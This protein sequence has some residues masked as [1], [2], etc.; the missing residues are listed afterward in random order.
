MFK[1]SAILRTGAL[2]IGAPIVF[3][4]AALGLLLRAQTETADAERWE[5]HSKDVISRTAQLRM[6]LTRAHAAVRGAYVYRTM[7]F[8]K[9]RREALSRWP[10]MLAD[11]RRF[12]ADNPGQQAQIDRIGRAADP[13]FA[14]FT[15]MTRLGASGQW[16]AYRGEL[17]T[18]RGKT[19]ADNVET[20]LS[21]FVQEEGHLDGQRLAAVAASRLYERNVLLLIAGL[22]IVLA[23]A[24]LVVF[25]RGFSQRLARIAVNGRRLATGDALLDPL[26]GDDE[27]AALDGVLHDSARRLA[28]AA[29]AEK[30]Y[31]AEL[32]QRGR[33]L[34]QANK[35]L[36]FRRQENETFVYSVSHDLRSP[37]VNVQ[38]FTKELTQA[39]EDLRGAIADT[40]VDASG[41]D[42][43]ARIVDHDI[44]EAVSFI[45]TAVTR[46]SS[47]VDALLRL[48]R[49]GRV[50]FSAQRVELGPIVERIT[51]AMRAT[52]E[53][54]GAHVTSGP[55]PAVLGDAVSI[56]QVFAN[57][58][59][60]AL[61]YLDPARPGRVEIGLDQRSGEAS[62]EAIV[63][64]RDNGLGIP[65]RYLSKLFVPFERLHGDV[66]KGEGIGLALAKRIVDRHGGRIWVESTE[67]AGTTFF[68]ALPRAI[69][70]RPAPAGVS[71]SAGTSTEHGDR[72]R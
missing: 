18:A 9:D 47:I 13:Y 60:N 62:S 33:A 3:E 54:Q 4:L 34:E 63:Y 44:G 36:L 10:A 57:L 43:L 65:Q 35:D 48:S 28:A 8:E 59:G 6:M 61:N 46:L 32:E 50:E 16:E 42:R 20:A 7:E 22:A 71:T 66:A 49:A 14:Y 37:L 26:P 64:V 69:A 11:L 17:L 30:R 40:Q 1:H 70:G 23:V 72:L 2:L 19:L 24:L 51:R 52:I 56:E 68:V 58:I 29:A 25:T 5:L 53:Q 38:G 41:R 55:L 15:E 45:Q 31:A 21:R 67:H 27:L 39:C 12:V